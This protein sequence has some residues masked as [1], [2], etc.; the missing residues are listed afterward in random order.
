MRQCGKYTVEYSTAIKNETL[1]SATTRMDLEDIT[2]SELSQSMKD[3]YHM[4]SLMLNLRNETNG[5]RE[6]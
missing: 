5:Q 6:K 3:K 1:P 2:L 4:N